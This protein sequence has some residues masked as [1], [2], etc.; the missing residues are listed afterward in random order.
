MAKL[1]FYSYTNKGGRPNNEDSIRGGLENG[2]GVFVLADGLGDTAWGKW[3][4]PSRR[5]PCLTA[6]LPPRSWM[7]GRWKSS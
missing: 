2:R 6:V 7:A 1:S 3:L 4:L 5:K